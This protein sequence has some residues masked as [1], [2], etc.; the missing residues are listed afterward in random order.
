[1][2]IYEL[3]DTGKL[4]SHGGKSVIVAIHKKGDYNTAS[5][6]RGI[7]LQNVLGKIYTSVLTKRITVYV[8]IFD[9]IREPQA[10]FRDSY[11]TTDNAYVLQAI[12]KTTVKKLVK[13]MLL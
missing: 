3:Y 2:N 13:C 11:S 6:Y 8:N 4:Q 7:S 9:E 5:K 12:V 1:L 10:W